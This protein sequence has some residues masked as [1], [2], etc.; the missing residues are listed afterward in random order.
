MRKLNV[1]QVA[2]IVF[3]ILLSCLI[4]TSLCFSSELSKTLNSFDRQQWNALDMV[5]SYHQHQF[6][7]KHFK[8]N[9]GSALFLCVTTKF[10]KEV[11]DELCKQGYIDQKSHVFD[12]ERGFDGQDV[13]RYFVASLA[14]VG[15]NLT[16]GWIYNKWFKK[17]EITVTKYQ[18]RFTKKGNIKYKKVRIGPVVNEFNIT[19]I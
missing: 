2:G 15:V 12:K 5:L 10:V 14:S 1:L 19:K 4:L 3:L 6:L 9:N 8:V 16:T 17:P 11:G 7:T 13:A 18:K